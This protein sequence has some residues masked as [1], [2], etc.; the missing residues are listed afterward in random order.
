MAF[1]IRADLNPALL[2]LAWLIGHWEG[3]GR[4]R[5]P[6]GAEF[7]YA[8]TVDFAENGQD[9]LHYVM[10]LF[11]ADESGTPVR[12]VAFET[13]F[14]RPKPDGTVE[15][16]ITQPEGVA[17]IYLGRVAGAKIELSTD[18]VVRTVTADVATS[19]GHRLYGNVES[20]LLFTYDR[21][22]ADADLQ[23]YLWARLKRA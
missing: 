7:E 8:A 14:W 4:G 20:D 6:D 3:A 21:G 22:T 2:G 18:V 5:R 10:Q 13:G 17:E 16:L 19:G 1:E 11:E 15:V 12:P 9:W 23:P